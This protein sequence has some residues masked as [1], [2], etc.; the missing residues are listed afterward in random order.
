MDNTFEKT[1]Q[2][3]A[4][5][6]EQIEKEKNELKEKLSVYEDIKYYKWLSH[7]EISLNENQG[8]PE[9]GGLP[10]PRIEMR[11]EKEHESS[12]R[13][14]YGLVKKH[15]LGHIEFIPISQTTMG[16]TAQREIEVVKSAIIKNDSDTINNYLPFRDGVH[17]KYDAMSLQLPIYVRCEELVYE[18]KINENDR[19]FILKNIEY[20]KTKI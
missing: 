8:K 12:V 18:F 7:V 13:A 5:K 1:L 17:V 4:E 16:G 14:I 19:D 15:Y 9:N 20:K 6:M 10:L 3:M 11:F 2:V